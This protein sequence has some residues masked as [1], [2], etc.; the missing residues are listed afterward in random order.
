MSSFWLRHSN[1]SWA[2]KQ[3]CPHKPLRRPGCRS[4]RA[5]WDSDTVR[6]SHQP[7]IWSGWVDVL[8]TLQRRFPAV[9]A[10]AVGYLSTL[11]DH[12]PHHVSLAALDASRATLSNAGILIPSWDEVLNGARP[13]WQHVWQYYTTAALQS[14]MQAALL[15]NAAPPDAAR[16]RSCKGRNNSRWLTAVPYNEALTLS[17]PIL[18][19]LLRRRLGMPII[20]DT[21]RCE[22]PTCQATLDPLGH[23]RSA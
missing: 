8:P 3:A 19:C 9:V 20:A 4:A 23:H 5:A 7:S 6:L 1:T 17:N 12:R 13:E 21:E 14:Q 15:H 22:G 11:A 18:Q 16:L 2:V 10:N